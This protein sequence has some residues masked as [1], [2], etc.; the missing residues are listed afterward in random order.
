MRFKLA[1][2]SLATSLFTSVES[3]PLAPSTAI[4]STNKICDSTSTVV[5]KPRSSATSPLFAV[6]FTDDPQADLEE[7]TQNY[8]KIAEL[9][10]QAKKR[11]KE[12]QENIDIM[13]E[14]RVGVES[15]TEK[16]M[17]RLK[18]DLRYAIF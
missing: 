9:L 12:A 10:D 3:F 4:A 8:A 16:V 13:L 14:E 1:A 15:E 18:R 6:F 7:V 2:I 5:V 17:S 11:E